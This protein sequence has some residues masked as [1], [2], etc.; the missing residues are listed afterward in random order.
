MIDDVVTITKNT[1]DAISEKYAQLNKAYPVP[2][3]TDSA[4]F[5]SYIPSDGKVLDVGCGHGR[6]CAYFLSCNL[7]V[8]GIDVSERLLHIARATAP[9]AE[10]M[11][12]DMRDVDFEDAVFDGL[13]CCASFLHIP[14]ADATCT[15]H[16]FYR[17]LRDGGILFLSIQSHMNAFADVVTR[18]SPRESRV[19]DANIYTNIMIP[20]DRTIRVSK[21]RVLVVSKIRPSSTR[22]TSKVIMEARAAEIAILTN[23]IPISRRSSPPIRTTNR[24]KSTMT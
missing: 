19:H 17:V 7:T 14:L 6:D 4:T 24:A 21:F 23:S 15:L 9:S 10:F 12:M 3:Q 2:L 11:V 16:E 13:W 1:Y 18:Y 20:N 5:V 22:L 8:T